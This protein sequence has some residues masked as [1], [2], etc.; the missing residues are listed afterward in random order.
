[1][2]KRSG[3]LVRWQLERCVLARHS[4]ESNDGVTVLGD[5][6][7]LYRSECGTRI[8]VSEQRWRGA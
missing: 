8:D 1:M 6:L 2:T 4:K 3:V 7:G 5:V